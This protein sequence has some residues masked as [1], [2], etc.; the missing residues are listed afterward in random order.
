MP[1]SSMG[2]STCTSMPTIEHKRE[3]QKGSRVRPDRLLTT[4]Y[5]MRLGLA[6]A[7]MM[8]RVDGVGEISFD[9]PGGSPS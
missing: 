2:G 6:S 4:L 1:A 3:G 5:G 9:S 7:I 8:H